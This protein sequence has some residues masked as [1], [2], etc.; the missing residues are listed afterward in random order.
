[1]R[2]VDISFAL[3]VVLNALS[4]TGAHKQHPAASTVGKPPTEAQQNTS[5][6]REK[7]SSTLRSSLYQIGFLGSTP[8][9]WLIP[10][11]QH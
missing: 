6:A 4:P 11:L 2:Q 10:V 9:L 7:S 3:T 5:A 1:M 8:A